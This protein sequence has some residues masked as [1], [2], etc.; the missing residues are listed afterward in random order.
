MLKKEIITSVLENYKNIDILRELSDS[1]ISFLKE[2]IDKIDMYKLYKYEFHGVFHS[3]K[4]M[5]FAYLIGKYQNLSEEDMKILLDAAI[6]HDVGRD[7]DF[8]ET[9]HGYSSTLKYDKLFSDDD[10]YKEEINFS[11]LKAITEVHSVDDSKKWKVFINYD[12]DDEYYD[13]YSVLLDIL[14][15][16]DALDRARFPKS[17]KESIKEEFLRLDFSKNLVDFAFSLNNIY[18]TKIDQA[19]FKKYQAEYLNGNKQNF[20]LHGIGFDFSKMESIL[21]NGILSGYTAIQKGVVVSRN[22]EGNNADMWISVIDSMDV[23]KQG[24]AYKQFA[25]NNISFFANVNNYKI[26]EKNFGKAQSKGLPI[27]SGLY[28][29]ESF[30]FSEIPIED[31][32]GIILPANSDK[33]RLSELNYLYCSANFKTI[34]SRV[35]NYCQYIQSLTG[36][37]ID[38]S[39]LNT[40]ILQLYELEIDFGTKSA[41]YQKENVKQFFDDIDLIVNKINIELARWISASFKQYLMLSDIEPTVSMVVYDILK[42]K[43]IQYNAMG[44]NTTETVIRLMSE[45]KDIDSTNRTKKD[46]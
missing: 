34:K 44:D 2:K 11:L 4:V 19:N 41:E 21:D 5:L 15:D 3:Q 7:S 28:E 10:F 12:I 29:D 46:Y 25:N 27:D 24:T 36:I 40:L 37:T 6:Y 35:E 17:S 20:C 16:A 1:E 31:I 30:V 26:G 14:K 42:R 8:E 18:R 9:T 38:S 43:N 45:V 32:Y 22:F 33:L 23:S 39:M 13:R